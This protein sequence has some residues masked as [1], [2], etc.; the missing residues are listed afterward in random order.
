M[1]DPVDDFLFRRKRRDA[2][3]AAERAHGSVADDTGL[4]QDGADFEPPE[5]EAAVLLEARDVAEDDAAVFKERAAPLDGFIHL[6][7][8][9]VDGLAQMGEDGLRERARLFDVGVD[10]GIEFL[11]GHAVLRTGG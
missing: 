9:G 7:A 3:D 4:A 8:S 10:F 2:G 1:S 11:R 6:R 5:T